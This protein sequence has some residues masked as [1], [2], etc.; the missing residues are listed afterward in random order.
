LEAE[1][2]I[3]EFEDEEEE[4]D[5]DDE[6]IIRRDWYIMAAMGPNVQPPASQYR[7]GKRDIDIEYNFHHTFI[8]YG[9]DEIRIASTYLEDQKWL[10]RIVDDNIPDI[11]V[12]QL[13]GAQQ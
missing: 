7:F 5:D 13:V 9:D 4:D 8:L 2:A 3:D 11:D 12:S 6:C 1:E 10:I